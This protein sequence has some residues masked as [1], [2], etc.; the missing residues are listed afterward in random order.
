MFVKDMENILIKAMEY[1]IKDIK[2]DNGYNGANLLRITFRDLEELKVFRQYICSQ[3]LA[4]NIL[5]YNK[6]CLICIFEP[7]TEIYGLKE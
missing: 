4:T 6:K 7:N 3:D 5:P 1:D 2:T